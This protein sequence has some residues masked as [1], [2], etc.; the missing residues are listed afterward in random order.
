[1][2]TLS[3]D[4]FNHLKNLTLG[5]RSIEELSSCSSSY[6]GDSGLHEPASAEPG[7]GVMV[8]L[9]GDGPQ[10]QI[11]AFN[12][13]NQLLYQQSSATSSAPGEPASPASNNVSISDNH[14]IHLL[15]S[16]ESL[17]QLFVY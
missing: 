5:H 6:G 1:M 8:S 4:F 17:R 15:L 9:S 12:P 7:E 3:L 11:R 16:R 10:Q 2:W 13:R 14:H